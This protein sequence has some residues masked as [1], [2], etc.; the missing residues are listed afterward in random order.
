MENYFS[1]SDVARRLGATPRDISDLLYRRE[2][3]DDL[4][5]IIGGRRLIPESYI[6]QI[7][8]AL[9]R[10]KRLAVTDRPQAPEEDSHAR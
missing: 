4:C 10:H 1:V 6:H 5:P 3:R 2:L 9:M 8:A 7:E